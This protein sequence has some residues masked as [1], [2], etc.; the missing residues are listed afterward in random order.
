MQE[1]R[2]AARGVGIVVSG[3][4]PHCSSLESLYAV[5]DALE[6]WIPYSCTIFQD[7]AYQCQVS[8]PLTKD[9]AATG[10]SKCVV[11]FLGDV[12]NVG[13]PLQIFK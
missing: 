9:G 2:D 5:S 8:I 11:C 12:D 6:E 13:V 4:E 3:N 10:E 1:L 7:W